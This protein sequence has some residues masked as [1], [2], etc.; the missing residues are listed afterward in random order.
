MLPYLDNEFLVATTRLDSFLFLNLGCL[1]FCFIGVLGVFF[2]FFFKMAFSLHP[3]SVQDIPCPHCSGLYIL[4][5]LSRHVKSAHV[6]ASFISQTS[7]VFYFCRCTPLLCFSLVLFLLLLGVCFKL[8]LAPFWGC[9]SFVSRV[10]ICFI[11]S[12]EPAMMKLGRLFA[13]PLTKLL[14]T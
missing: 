6:L 8:S 14:K 4:S 3:P 10:F 7:H 13:Y 11:G 12:F 1:G 5:S 2:L 9:L